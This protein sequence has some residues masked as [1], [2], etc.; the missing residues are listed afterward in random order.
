MNIQDAGRQGV[1]IISGSQIMIENNHFED[2][3]YYIFDVEPNNDTE[4]ATNITFRNNTMGSWGLDVGVGGGFVAVG[5]DTAYLQINN[6]TVTGNSFTKGAIV[7]DGQLVSTLKSYY[8]QIQ[9]R[10]LNNII[11]T[12]NKSSQTSPEPI[13]ELKSIDGLTVTGNIQPLSSGSLGSYINNT[14]AVTSPNP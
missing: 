12:N 4:S 7:K 9:H 11:F 1:S 13:I 3:G 6:I 2:M 5:S 14:N 10:R 8:N